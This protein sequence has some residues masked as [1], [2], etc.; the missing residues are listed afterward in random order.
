MNCN[1]FYNSCFVTSY[2]VLQHALV[3]SCVN[4]PYERFAKKKQ[5]KKTNVQETNCAGCMTHKA[6]RRDKT[7]RHQLCHD[8][9]RM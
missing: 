6:W 8:V 2:L 5:N 3:C 7:I 1:C 4:K 9:Y